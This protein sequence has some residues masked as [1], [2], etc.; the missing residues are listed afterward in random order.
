M[1]KKNKKVARYLQRKYKNNLKNMKGMS[2]DISQFPEYSDLK[3]Q[4][5]IV[6]IN[7]NGKIESMSR[8]SPEEIAAQEEKEILIKQAKKEQQ[9]I[10]KGRKKK[11]DKL[12]AVKEDPEPISKDYDKL[13]DNYMTAKKK[14]DEEDDEK[15]KNI[16]EKRAARIGRNLID[17]SITLSNIT[18]GEE[19]RDAINITGQYDV[20]TEQKKKYL[21]K[22]DPRRTADVLE[23]L[24]DPKKTLDVLQTPTYDLQKLSDEELIKRLKL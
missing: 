23:S 21:G 19:W 16:F 1:N 14:A 7:Q 5:V 12:A 11:R 24:D 13:I 22:K 18:G 15:A 3:G 2:V 9:D 20:K 6:K 4:N 8:I 17:K 10:I